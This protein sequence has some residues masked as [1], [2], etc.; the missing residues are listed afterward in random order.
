MPGS[1]NFYRNIARFNDVEEYEELLIVR[2]DARLYFANANYFKEQIDHFAS[3]KGSNLKAIILD[4]EV[5]NNI[6]STGAA[7]LGTLKD[8]YENKNIRLFITNVKGPVR[9]AMAKSGLTQKVGSEHFFMSIQAAVDAYFSEVQSEKKFTK[10][11]N[12]T[13]IEP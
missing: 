8:Q 13:N 11:V 2:F 5:I 1:A 10:Y 4:A 6:D 3:E 12:Q 7:I 9:D